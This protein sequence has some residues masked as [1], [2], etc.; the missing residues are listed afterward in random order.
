M[1]RAQM[2]ADRRRVR[3]HVDARFRIDSRILA[4]RTLRMLSCPGRTRGNRDVAS[5]NPHGASGARPALFGHRHV[6]GAGPEAQRRRCRRRCPAICVCSTTPGSF[7]ARQKKNIDALEALQP[8]LA[9]S[10]DATVRRAAALSARQPHDLV[11]VV[12]DV[13]H[14]HAEECPGNCSMCGMYFALAIHVERGQRLV[15]QHEPRACQQ[16][17]CSIATRCCSLR[18]TAK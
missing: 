5:V 13:E 15:H 14:W 1:R 16:V 3:I 10:G 8:R 12:R 4:L 18:P 9:M 2:L 7:A 6:H 17:L 11:D